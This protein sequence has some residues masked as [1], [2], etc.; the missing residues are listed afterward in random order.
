MEMWAFWW[1]LMCGLRPAF[2]RTRTFLWF[3]TVVAGMIVRPDLAGVTSIVRGIGLDGRYY[4][5]LLDFFHS[6]AVDRLALRSLWTKAIRSLGIEC[7]FNGYAVFL[8]DGIKAPKEGRKMP[9]VKLL[10]QESDSNSKPEYIMGHSCQVVS[11]L[12]YACASFFAVPLGVEIHEGLVFS[13]RDR[14]TLNDK[15]NTLIASLNIEGPF[16]LV[17]DAAY[18]CAKIAGALMQNGNHLISRVRS[19]AVGFRPAIQP[20]KRKRGRPPKYG[21]KKTLRKFFDDVGL[22]TEASSPVAS[23]D[24]I[25]L[26]YFVA[27]LIWKPLG[28]LVRFVFV[29]HPVHGKTVFL[30]TDR[31]LTA[32]Q[33][34]ELYSRRFKIEVSFK[35]AIHTLGTYAYHFW[36]K[37]M[38]PVRRSSGDQYLHRASEEYRQAIR[39]KMNAYHLHL[40]V[41]L[42]AQGILQCLAAIKS[43]AVWSS[44][45]SW[46]RT[47]RPGIAPSEHVTALAMCGTINEFLSNS[48]AAGSWA[49]FLAAKSDPW[50]SR[51]SRTETG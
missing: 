24:G 4:D 17:A 10:H 43:E 6:A 15:L 3:V 35:Q 16:Y 33:V 48:R 23:E 50:R 34:I 29:I 27:D 9:A 8:A 31:S 2:A 26:L 12:C 39:R 51:L 44:F 7:R 22:F 46:I 47:I 40:Q 45:R 25:V 21:A 5:R 38:Q 49:K 37:A 41:G 32:L 36:M 1:N 13:N 20:K 11:I 28:E 14:R 18:A 42:I 30:S 19:N